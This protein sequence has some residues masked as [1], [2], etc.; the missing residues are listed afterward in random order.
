[1]ETSV[2]TENSRDGIGANRRTGEYIGGGALLGAVIGA[3]VGGG[4]GAAIGA[5][6]GAAAGAGTQILTRGRTVSVPAESL[7][8]F[9]L[10]EPL[11]VRPAGLRGNG[12]DSG[13]R[14]NA[15]STPAYRQGWRDG[16]S[17]LQRGTQRNPWN[18]N[19]WNDDQDH[20]D[21]IAGY[22]DARQ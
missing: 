6:A 12:S 20:R 10:E 5:G 16:Q 4:K 9:R 14:G 11:R 17:D 1:E 21:Y 18:N 19:S 2:D 15:P 13:V 7:I 8:T 3:I 22:H